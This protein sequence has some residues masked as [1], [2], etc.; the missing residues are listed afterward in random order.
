MKKNENAA[1]IP[2]I[3]RSTFDEMVRPL[4]LDMIAAFSLLSEDI[5]KILGKAEREKW[6]PEKIETEIKNLI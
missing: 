4:S 3:D 2:K 6:T 1:K 5:L